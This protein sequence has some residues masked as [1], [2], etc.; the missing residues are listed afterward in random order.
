ME[1]Y[2]GGINKMMAWNG[3]EAVHIH[4]DPVGPQIHHV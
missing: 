1:W 4:W 2:Y 3:L